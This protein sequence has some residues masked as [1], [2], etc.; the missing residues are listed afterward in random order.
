VLV[1]V[2]AGVLGALGPDWA[3][4]VFEDCLCNQ[5]C[6]KTVV[7]AESLSIATCE[8]SLL[9]ACNTVY[10][11]GARE[12]RSG[13]WCGIVHFSAELDMVQQH[14]DRWHQ[15]HTLGLDVCPVLTT[16]EASSWVVVR[17]G[18]AEK[19][20][21]DAPQQSTVWGWLWFCRKG[22]EGPMVVLILI[23][24]LLS[25]A[26]RAFQDWWL[27]LLHQ[28][29]KEGMQ[30][31]GLDQEGCV[32]V[33]LAAVVTSTFLLGLA[34]VIW[35]SIVTVSA[36]KV[37]HREATGAMSKTAL[38]F[39]PERHQWALDLLGANMAEA[40]TSFPHHIQASITC[41]VAALASFIVMT[42]E[43]V[44][45]RGSSTPKEAFAFIGIPVL[46]LATG[47]WSFWGTDNALR[48]V[49]YFMA[50]ARGPVRALLASTADSM[51]CMR[52]YPHNCAALETMQYLLDRYSSAQLAVCAVQTRS[53]LYVGSFWSLGAV[54]AAAAL[55]ILKE[56]DLLPSSLSSVAVAGLV[57][58]LATQVVL[59]AQWSL[60]SASHAS[61]SFHAFVGRT[62]Y[63]SRA[64]VP[65]EALVES[66]ANLVETLSGW[67]LEN[68]LVP[69]SPLVPAALVSPLS[70]SIA[71]ARALSLSAFFLSAVFLAH[72]PPPSW[73]LSG[74][75]LSIHQTAHL[76][77]WCCIWCRMPCSRT[78]ARVVLQ[79][80]L[81]GHVSGHVSDPGTCAHPQTVNLHVEAGQRVMAVGRRGSGVETLPLVLLRIARLSRGKVILNFPSGLR[82][83]VGSV[84][85]ETLR[86]CIKYVRR[87]PV[88]FASSVRENL[89]QPTNMGTK[90]N[91]AEARVVLQFVGLLERADVSPLELHARQEALLGKHMHELSRRDR[92][93][94]AVARALLQKPYM[95][96][97]EDLALS[98]DAK[99]MDDL[100][101]MFLGNP[102][103][104]TLHIST[105]AARLHRF[106]R[107]LVFH[108]GTVVQDGAPKTLVSQ[109]GVLSN[110]LLE[111]GPVADNLVREQLGAATRVLPSPV[112]P[113]PFS[114]SSPAQHTT[115]VEQRERDL[116]STV[117][118]LGPI[119]EMD[120][121]DESG[122]AGV[123]AGKL[124]KQVQ[125]VYAPLDASLAH[126]VS[127]KDVSSLFSWIQGCVS[128]IHDELRL[129]LRT[130][131]DQGIVQYRYA[132]F[133]VPLTAKISKET[134]HFL[135]QCCRDSV[136]DVALINKNPLV[137]S[138]ACVQILRLLPRKLVSRN[139]LARMAP[140]FPRGQ[141]PKEDHACGLIGSAIQELL[142]TEGEYLELL[143][144]V[145]WLL[146]HLSSA[147]TAQKLLFR[148]QQG[149]YGEGDD[150][151]AASV[152]ASQM[153]EPLAG[154]CEE[155][156][157]SLSVEA[158]A[159]FILHY[160]RILEGQVTYGDAEQPP[161]LPEQQAPHMPPH[162]PQ[163]NMQQPQQALAQSPNTG[164]RGVSPL[165]APS[166]PAQQPLPPQM[167]QQQQQT[168]M[169]QAPGAPAS[170]AVAAAVSLHRAFDDPNPAAAVARALDMRGDVNELNEDG[171]TVLMVACSLG[172]PD[173]VRL[174]SLSLLI[175]LLSLSSPNPR[176]L[177]SLPRSLSSSLLSLSSPSP[178]PLL[179]HFS[180]TL[181][182][183]PLS[184]PSL[185]SLS[186]LPLS[187]LPLPA[188]PRAIQ[189][190]NMS[191][192]DSQYFLPP[193]T[194][195]FHSS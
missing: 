41:F 42:V 50:A 13:V 164:A 193:S 195:P 111:C 29:G 122:E 118:V 152:L 97:L 170:A 27:L 173:V 194:Y 94:L 136:A 36:A 19:A 113:M 14:S 90:Y 96:M 178:L 55:C 51:R 92:M 15:R 166:Q 135:K 47:F 26:L 165:V 80:L 57:L 64:L 185:L 114:P 17:M 24:G 22:G 153:S 88:M 151:P 58:A 145:V 112:A 187:S 68:V 8:G 117:G 43:V 128:A 137:L 23:I 100:D 38:V 66:N 95:L 81:S 103:L 1:S 121:L 25:H 143:V 101:R 63:M 9:E 175:P 85:L 99:S 72:P 2:L 162:S 141:K 5:L 189:T 67:T 79:A 74:I 127:Q 177:L 186:P 62:K 60:V 87:S 108:N 49:S 98:I 109:P 31:S 144:Q 70:L 83:D 16:Q 56:G 48:R 40:M 35:S 86:S 192:T 172:M 4:R 149:L 148:R 184:S 10:L 159:F 28:G 39:E 45:I 131:Q 46:L 174:V 44:T 155:P 107:V 180:S 167:P 120:S 82:L 146:S 140:A 163:T 191:A 34:N 138:A 7:L 130:H 132:V 160:D 123:E 71:C 133:V 75:F 102:K 21:V 157:G 89:W 182:P 37:M 61:I 158:L 139:F 179:S 53:L 69:S 6:V 52:I 91:P 20:F 59:L 188:R 73:S 77:S 124:A 171:F 76:A 142:A 104:I 150:P 168:H 84:S 176:P 110:M 169:Q 54:L 18:K 78:H 125:S 181:S 93:L 105:V 147:L 30:I 129:D 12:M 33:L 161:P 65:E 183:L 3:V 32:W 134:E 190:S 115:G 11:M 106:Q 154:L 126:M 119:S 116:A 156:Y